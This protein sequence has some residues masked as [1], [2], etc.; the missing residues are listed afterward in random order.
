MSMRQYPLLPYLALGCDAKY[1]DTPSTETNVSASLGG[2]STQNSSSNFDQSSFLTSES[3]PSEAKLASAPI[4]GGTDRM[5]L[6]TRNTRSVTSAL[7]K[8]LPAGADTLVEKVL[9][10]NF[11]V[12]LSILR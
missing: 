4:V 7:D 10:A 1:F 12:Q 11:L 2:T 8:K 6:T 5:L 3:N 9:T